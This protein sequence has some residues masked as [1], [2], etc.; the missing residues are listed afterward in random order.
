MFLG[1]RCGQRFGVLFG[2]PQLQL[3]AV[4]RQPLLEEVDQAARFDGRG[5]GHMRGVGGMRRGFVL[6]DHSLNAALGVAA[7]AEEIL[8]GFVGFILIEFELGFGNVELIV[9]GVFARAACL[10]LVG[11]ELVDALFVGVQRVLG[12]AQVRLD[13]FGFGAQNGGMH[14]RVANG[15]GEC[16]IHFLIAEVQGFLGEGLL[17]RAGGHLG[18]LLGGEQRRLVDQ[19]RLLRG[20]WNVRCLRVGCG[21]ACAHQRV[22]SRAQKKHEN[23]G[24][25]PLFGFHGASNCN[26]PGALCQREAAAVAVIPIGTAAVH[27]AKWTLKGQIEARTLMKREFMRKTRLPNSIFFALILVAAVQLNY[28]AQRLPDIVGSHFSTSG[29]ASAWQTKFAFLSVELVVIVVAAIISFGVPRLIAAMPA[30]A[31]NLP[32]KDFWL[33]PERREETFF[34]LRTQMAWFGCALLA[35]LLFVM[36]LVFRANLQRP[37]RLNNAAFIPALIAFIAFSTIWTIRF[38][39][40]FYRTDN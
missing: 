1:K 40:H 14:L 12:F 24:R 30:S 27:R 35:F 10:G 5:D 7:R 19:R 25:D 17:L 9:E 32:N 33:S 20:G 15:G 13:L 39:V 34:F 36:E 31:I 29:S 18:E 23:D 4:Q 2:A 11:G 26:T 6:V 38:V 28:Y 3:F 16:L 37:P 22:D 21:L 8:L